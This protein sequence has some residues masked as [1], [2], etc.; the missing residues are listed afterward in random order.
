MFFHESKIIFHFFSPLIDL[1]EDVPD[2]EI[3]FGDEAEGE[4]KGICIYLYTY[5]YE[6]LF[7]CVYIYLYIYVHEINLHIYLYFYISVFICKYIYVFRNIEGNDS[8]RF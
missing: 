4:E 1:T 7:V 2:G 8:S 6:Y 5:R 3:I